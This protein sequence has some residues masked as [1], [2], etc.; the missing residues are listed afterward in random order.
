M[1]WGDYGSILASG[2]SAHLPRKDGLMQLER[3]GPFI[4]PIS[5]PGIG[6]IIVTD[7]FRAELES[8]GLSGFTFAP[9]MKARIVELNWEAW[10][11]EDGDQPLHQAAHRAERRTWQAERHTLAVS[12]A[13]AFGEGQLPDG[14]RIRL[15]SLAR[16][17][18]AVDHG[19]AR[20]PRPR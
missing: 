4:P 3:T 14:D 16:E 12:I 20:S 11:D 2:M 17:E 18:Q 6:D 7:A 8:S 13:Y 10:A 15:V 19:P 1:P 9:V 5:L